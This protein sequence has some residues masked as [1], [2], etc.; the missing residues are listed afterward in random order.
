MSKSSM[1]AKAFKFGVGVGIVAIVVDTAYN[2]GKLD[3]YRECS[4][5]VKEELSGLDNVITNEEEAQ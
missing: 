4:E 1:F 3:A 5:I 2:K